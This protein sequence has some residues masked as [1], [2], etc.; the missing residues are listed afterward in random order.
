MIDKLLS[1]IDDKFPLAQKDTGSFSKPTVNGMHFHIRSF[2]AMGLGHV[3]AMEA[4]GFFGLMKMDTLILNPFERDMPLLAYDRIHV[5]GKDKLL[6]ELYNTMLGNTDVSSLDAVGKACEAIPSFDHGTHWY[7]TILLPQS[8]FKQGK[9][10]DSAVLNSACTDFLSH[11]L[12]LCRSA[13]ICDLSAKKEKASVYT[14][15]LLQNGGPS[16][17]IFIK[18]LGKESTTELFRNFLFGA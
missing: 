3:S 9:K 2:Y 15:G 16:T 18:H 13:P 8:I 1:F 12:Q 17:T 11:Y 14:N 6:L 10:R 4:S 7:D 5:M